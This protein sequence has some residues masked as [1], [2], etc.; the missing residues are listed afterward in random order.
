[1]AIINLKPFY[2]DDVHLQK[3]FRKQVTAYGNVIKRVYG[4]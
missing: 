1:M 3:Q 4:C 2:K